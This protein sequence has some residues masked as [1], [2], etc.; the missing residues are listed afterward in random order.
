[1]LGQQTESMEQGFL[2]SEVLA[3]WCLQVID[4]ELQIVR[5]VLRDLVLS[6]LSDVADGLDQLL[7]GSLDVVSIGHVNLK[8]HVLNRIFTPQCELMLGD[9]HQGQCQFKQDG[10]DVLLA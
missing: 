7:I 6:C 5:E 1:M 2:V 4:Q 8:A 10:L 3:W 9:E